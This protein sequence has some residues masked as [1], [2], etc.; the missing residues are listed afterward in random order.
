[1]G[2]CCAVV[3]TNN[4]EN[5]FTYQQKTSGIAGVSDRNMYL[6]ALSSPKL[7]ANFEEEVI[8][9][10]PPPRSEGDILSSP[11][12]KAFTL[13]DLKN[14]TR[15]FRP[16]NLIGEGGFGDVYKGWIDE[17]TLG[18]ASSGQGMVVA[19]KKLK[20]EGF[21]GHQEWLS[22]VN[23]LGQLHHPNL[24]K[25]IGYC[26]D[27]E[28][29]LLVYEYMPKGSLENHL[30]RRGAQPLSW[31]LRIKVAIGAARGLSFLHD[32]EQ[33]VIYRDFKASNILLDSEFNAKL[34]DFGL[35]KAGPT[36]DRSH[37]STRVLGTQGYAAPE[38]IAT[39]RLTARCD[40]YSFGVVLLELLT[41][42]RA[43]DKTKVGLEQNL[44]DWTK[45]YLGDRRKLFRIM[46][47]ELEGQYPQRE[48]FMVALLA[49]HCIS[50]AK[51]RPP[52]SE[53]LATLEELPVITKQGT[54]PS[55]F[56][57]QQQNP[58]A[59][60]PLRDNEPSPTHMNSP[61]LKFLSGC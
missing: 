23:Y 25:L 26:L 35:A 19:V 55:R 37:V 51:L 22:E 9:T 49:F 16:D 60:S 30:F 10:P 45:P 53:V 21:Q 56:L 36:G 14:A 18:A 43:L 6:S 20:P 13:N 48:A 38:Y 4:R 7:L 47:T 31:A 12:L 1:M 2:N 59:R 3:L 32:S 42:R 54:S 28:N 40:V 17:Q 33:Q 8:R 15:S 5:S 44:V 58:T 39:G 27:G 41:G 50:E 24:V 52:M 61:H 29:R 11:H 46:D 34:S 57:S